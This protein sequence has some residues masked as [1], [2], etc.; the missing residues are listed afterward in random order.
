MPAEADLL[1]KMQ[2]VGTILQNEPNSTLHIDG[3]TK[4][5]SE[6]ST[7][8][9]TTGSTGKSLSLGFMEQS[10]GT[11]DNYMDSTCNIFHDIAK[12]LL[13][14]DAKDGD[15]QHKCGELIMC[16]KNLQTDRHIVNKSYFQLTEFHYSVLCAVMADYDGLSAEQLG[17]IMRINHTF[18]G[19]I[20]DLNS[21][22][23]SRL[24]T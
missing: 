24:V 7:F 4:K 13:L 15:V 1:S 5:F 11:A 23:P 8:K 21:T 14:T 3:T 10:G 2:Y 6:Y 9:I 17:N 18:Q 16:L 12:L 19:S 22:R 20:S